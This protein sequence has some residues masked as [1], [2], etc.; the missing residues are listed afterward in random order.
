MNRIAEKVSFDGLGTQRGSNLKNSMGRGS[1]QSRVHV[2]P[3]NVL[4]E[5]DKSVKRGADG[6]QDKGDEQRK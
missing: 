6:L 2:T 3:H 5:L 4:D 1:K